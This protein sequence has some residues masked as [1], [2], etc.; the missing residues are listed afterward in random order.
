MSEPPSLYDRDLDLPEPPQIS[1]RD[2]TRS[3]PGLREW[4]YLKVQ[5][6]VIAVLLAAAGWIAWS[7]AVERWR[8][9]YLARMMEHSNAEIYYGSDPEPEGPTL[10]RYHAGLKQKYLRAAERPWLSV[11]PDPPPP[12]EHQSR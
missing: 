4:R 11:P 3:R 6:V 5:L 7:M 12:T 10:V 9:D 2:P 1:L 8:H